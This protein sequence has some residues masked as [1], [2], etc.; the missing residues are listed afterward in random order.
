MIFL[1]LKNDVNV[2]V[3]PD[4]AGSVWFGPPGSA[5]GFISQWFRICTKMSQIRN[6]ACNQFQLNIMISDVLC[7]LGCHSLINKHSQRKCKNTVYRAQSV[8]KC[9][10]KKKVFLTIYSS[11]RI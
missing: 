5:S 2:P 10:N 3:I 8:K 4:G 6:T 11:V 1:S 7:F 9:M